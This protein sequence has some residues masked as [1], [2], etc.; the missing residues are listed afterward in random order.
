MSLLCDSSPSQLAGLTLVLRPTQPTTLTAPVPSSTA[1]SPVMAAAQMV[2]L[3]LGGHRAW[4]VLGA[5]PLHC[6][7]VLTPGTYL[8]TQYTDSTKWRR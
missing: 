7:P 8:P 1:A 2:A 6:P 5:L 4:V 3:L